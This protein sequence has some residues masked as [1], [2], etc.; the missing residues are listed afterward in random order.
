MH[1]AS[2]CDYHKN[3]K[4]ILDAAMVSTTEGF[5]DESPSFPMKKITV[6][7]P[8]A[9]KS[10][11][12]FTNKIDVLKKTAKHRVGYTKSKHI[13]MKVGSSLWNN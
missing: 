5:T 4:D 11:C 3:L 7:K 10:L 6:K 1:H 2:K 13:A 9:R 8:R 12:L